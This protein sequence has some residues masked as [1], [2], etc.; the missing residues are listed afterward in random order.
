MKRVLVPRKPPVATTFQRASPH[1]PLIKVILQKSHAG[2]IYGEG[3]R[4]FELSQG[5]LALPIRRLILIPVNE[6]DLK[7]GV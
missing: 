5:L 1:R 3:C 2:D 6:P 7:I 4:L